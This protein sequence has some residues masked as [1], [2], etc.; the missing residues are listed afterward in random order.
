RSVAC[1]SG[2]VESSLRSF[3]PGK[4]GS[5]DGL[6][7]VRLRNKR[8]F[9]AVFGW[10]WEWVEALG[11]LMETRD[12]TDLYAILLVGFDSMESDKGRRRKKAHVQPAPCQLNIIE[13]T[14]VPLS[15]FNY[16][17]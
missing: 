17:E 13:R 12:M 11:A 16:N 8:R 1:F 14:E 2:G 10:D 9:G 5:L 7:L 6:G 15:I 3:P 4:C